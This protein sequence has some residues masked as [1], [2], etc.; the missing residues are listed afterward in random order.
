MSRVRLQTI[1]ALA[2]ALLGAGSAAEG[3]ETVPP[4]LRPKVAPTASDIIPAP[5]DSQAETAGKAAKGKG[6]GKGKGAKGAKGAGGTD[7]MDSAGEVLRSA[8][9]PELT[10][11]FPIGRT[12]GG[13]AIP[14]Y[15]G[16]KLKSV[17]TADT[18][19]R[20]DERFLDLVNLVVKVYN[21]AGEHE[22]TIAMD[23]A[24]YDLVADELTSKTPST[25]EQPRFTMT[26]DTMIFQ[27]QTQVARLVGNVRLVVPDASRIAPDFG[28]PGEGRDAPRTP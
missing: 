18:V 17:M 8:L 19:T 22:A 12:F 14:S 27:N 9:P 25:I 1:A 3:Q 20:V 28:L 24:A 23:E 10:D 13:V 5:A 2:A 4:P 15:T 11:H 7:E 6:K 26:G 16:E 21:N